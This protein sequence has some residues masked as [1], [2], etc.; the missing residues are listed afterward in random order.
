MI[1]GN[2]KEPFRGKLKSREEFLE[3]NVRQ[4][5]LR[6]FTAEGDVSRDGDDLRGK[7]LFPVS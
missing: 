7:I 1:A 4:I 2:D 6:L 3:E 5:V